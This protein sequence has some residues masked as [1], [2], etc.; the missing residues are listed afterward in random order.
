[1]TS[2]PEP[3]P[4]IRGERVYLRAA[5]RDDVEVVRDPALSSFTL[6]GT[7][8]RAHFSR[9]EHHDVHV[10]SLLRDDWLALSRRRSWELD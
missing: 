10:M 1:M 5:E 2:V 3:R 6:E 4:I 9:G 8:R 7:K